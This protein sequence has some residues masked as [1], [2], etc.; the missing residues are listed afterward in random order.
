MYILLEYVITLLVLIFF[1]HLFEVHINFCVLNISHSYMK[2]WCHIWI[3]KF[4]L[5]NVQDSNCELTRKI[6]SWHN[7]F[8]NMLGLLGPGYE[9]IKI[10]IYFSVMT[11][12][13]W[14]GSTN[15]RSEVFATKHF[16]TE[17]FHW[18]FQRSTRVALV[19]LPWQ[20][21]PVSPLEAATMPAVAAEAA[22]APPLRPLP[23]RPQIL[24]RLSLSCCPPV[25]T[26]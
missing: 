2:C 15:I 9:V 13:L 3:I 19:T 16:H 6:A 26:R 1:R 21:R 5:R 17:R 18:L 12:I 24:N 23:L 11:S 22:A 4:I 10:P 8:R 14:D 25:F 20:Q 7:Y